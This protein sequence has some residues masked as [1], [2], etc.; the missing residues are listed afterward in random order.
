MYDQLKDPWLSSLAGNL[1]TEDIQRLAIQ[2]GAMYLYD[3]RTNNINVIQ[4]IDG[5][6]LRIT[7]PTDASKII[8]VGRV[9]ANQ[10]LNSIARW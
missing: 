1:T 5:V 6:W 2:K 4:E 10:I 9:R 7:T 3:A 8:S